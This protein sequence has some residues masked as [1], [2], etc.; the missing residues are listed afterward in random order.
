MKQKIVGVYR[1][2]PEDVQLVLREGDGGSFFT[3]PEKGHICRIKV[4]ADEGRWPMVVT[5][6]MHEAMELTMMRAGCRYT[7]SPDFG[8]DNGSYTFV[9]THTQFSEASARAAMFVAAA[10]P[11]LRKAWKKWRKRK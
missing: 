7:P 3:V 4:G 9:M 8:E 11:D 5:T 6:L 10:M 1:C 2:G